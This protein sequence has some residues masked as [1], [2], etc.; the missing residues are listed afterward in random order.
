MEKQHNYL[1]HYASPY[2]DPVKAHEYYM[3]NR[4]LKGNTGSKVT[5]NEEGKARQAAIKSYI[6]DSKSAD[7]KKNSD[8]RAKKLEQHAENRTKKIEDS[9]T[10]M[11]KGIEQHTKDM[12]S[13]ID[14]IRNRLDRMTDNEKAVYSMKL[15]NDIAKLRDENN[16]KKEELTKAY[17]NARVGATNEYNT[18]KQKEDANYKTSN[19][20]IKSGYDKMY[21]DEIAKLM[22]DPQF[23]KV[24]KSKGSKGKSS[25]SNKATAAPKPQQKAAK[26]TSYL[27]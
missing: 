20:Q 9:K 1:I 10:A 26:R 23:I 27:H 16:K 11:T 19:E 17:E 15:Q 4:E 25:G 12:A 13:K 6:N 22:S 8:E 5:L 21:Q 24:S 14:S 7:L 2:Y 3:K 18:N